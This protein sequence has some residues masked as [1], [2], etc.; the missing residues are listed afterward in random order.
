MLC[1]NPARSQSLLAC[2]YKLLCT[3]AGPSEMQ[4][5]DDPTYMWCV[6]VAYVAS[7][8]ACYYYRS[9]LDRRVNKMNIVLAAAAGEMKEGLALLQCLRM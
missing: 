5:A 2:V 3:S 9:A 8:L 7:S 1:T 6:Q 4:L